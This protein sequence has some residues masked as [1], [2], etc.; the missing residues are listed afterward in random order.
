MTPSEAKTH[1]RPASISS[2]LRATYRLLPPAYQRRTPFLLAV[3]LVEALLDVLGLASAVPLIYHLSGSSFQSG[4]PAVPVLRWLRSA[5]GQPSDATFALVLAALVLVAF[6]LRHVFGV[7]SARLQQRFVY[8]AAIELIESQYRTHVEGDHEATRGTNTTL[9][10]RRIG[11]F[12]LDFATGIVLPACT[13]ATEGL[14]VVLIA[15][16]LAIFQPYIAPVLSLVVIPPLLVTR[17]IVRGKTHQA[18]VKRNYA[19]AQAHRTLAEAL[20]AVV[21]VRLLNKGE[22]FLQRM[23]GYFRDYAAA[24]TRLTLLSLLPRQLVE[25]NAILAVVLLLVAS[26]LVERNA[27]PLLPL[28]AVVLGAAYRV[29]PSMTRLLAAVVRL[30]STAYVLDDLRPP[31]VRLETGDAATRPLAFDREVRFDRVSFRYSGSDRDVIEDASLTI[32]KGECVGLVG[33][34]GSGKTTIINMLLR[35][36][37]EQRGQF[38]VDGRALGPEDSIRWRQVVGYVEQD[39]YLLDGTVAENIAFGERAEDISAAR[40]ER[41]V[42][43]A[44]LQP[45]VEALPKGL[46]TPIGEVGALLSGGQRQRI[47]IARALY[48]EPAL[49]I[50]DEATSA[51]DAVTEA[52]LAQTVVELKREGRTI[53]IVAHRGRLIDLCDRSYRLQ[54]GRIEREASGKSAPTVTPIG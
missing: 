29:M 25:L 46:D 51:L 16:G 8:G 21:H 47:A 12:P 38:L 50:L 14:V 30:R 28:L 48:R 26:V 44:A 6:V 4:R 40:M 9:L 53:V 3:L 32:P 10:D 18:G 19:R 37:R 24:E 22:F 36:L 39:S 15:V 41:A 20:H 35:F 27:A 5:L 52:E 2:I 54:A 23:T 42:R 33:P 7:F 17:R 1:V 13:I 49:L 31:G 34:S 45:L 43:S 11:I